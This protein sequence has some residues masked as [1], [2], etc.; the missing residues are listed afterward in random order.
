MNVFFRELKANRKALLIWSVCMFL[1]VLSGMGKYSAYESGS[2]NNDIFEKMPFSLRAL[3]G[4]GSF[5]VSTVGGFFAFLFPYLEIT[6]AIHAALLGAGILAK[7]ELDKTTEFLMVKPL[8]R[9]RILEAKLSAAVCNILILNLVTLAGSILMV[10]NYSSQASIKKEVLLLML[11]MFAVQLIFF[12]VGIFFAAFLRK[13]KAAG[14]ITMAVL[15]GSFVLSKITDFTDRLNGLNILAPFKYFSIED[16]VN[17]GTLN[18][19]I[20]LI[21][22][23]LAVILLAAGISFYRRR[24]LNI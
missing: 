24:D 9:F 13:P 20:L 1:L 10:S 2:V 11:S 18:P 23:I 3:F 15:L 17:K 4:M 12:S 21:S 7:E 16:V 22:M 14:S 5:D 6:V 19:G 8:S